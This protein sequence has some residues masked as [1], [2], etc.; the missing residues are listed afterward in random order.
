MTKSN[1]TNASPASKTERAAVYLRMSTDKQDKSIERQR[2]LVIPYAE[3][4]GYRIVATYTDE[5]ISACGPKSDRPAFM[6]LR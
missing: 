2:E 5:G 4:K 1:S 6:R 3:K